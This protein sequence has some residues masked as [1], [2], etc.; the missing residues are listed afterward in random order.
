M[1]SVATRLRHHNTSATPRRSV[2]AD[3]GQVGQVA[4]RQG[5]PHGVVRDSWLWAPWNF[6]ELWR[7]R[8]ERQQ[9]N[10]DEL[11]VSH[12]AAGIASTFCLGHPPQA[13]HRLAAPNVSQACVLPKARGASARSAAGV[14][15][16]SRYSSRIGGLRSHRS[17]HSAGRLSSAAVSSPAISGQ[18]TA[19]PASIS[20]SRDA[21]QFNRQA[22]TR[23]TGRLAADDTLVGVMI[24]K[25]YDE[26]D[27][28]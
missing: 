20:G 10:V 3:K 26:I 17:S 25:Q 15:H 13:S 23:K 22:L 24:A 1:P 6:L 18:V 5:R 16:I 9:C 21:P 19:T 8:K 2:G 4:H 7:A 27:E 12:P 28:I 14:G 11:S